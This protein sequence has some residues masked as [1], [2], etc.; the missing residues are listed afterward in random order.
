MP[1]TRVR[2]GAFAMAGVIAG[3]AGGLYVVILGGVG[4]QTFPPSDSILVFSMAV[5]G[6]LGSIS[7]ALCG[8]ALIEWLGI[9]FPQYQLVLTGFG[10]L[11]LLMFFP[12][13]L[14]GAFEWAR[15]RMLLVIARRRGLS[16]SVWGDAGFADE[17]TVRG[18]DGDGGRRRGCRATACR[19]CAAVPPIK[20]RR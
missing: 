16:T 12:S 20:R 8:V 10:M 5:I 4:Y 14:A 2:L 11:V 13:G 6:G 18:S 19:R 15:D 9:A 7:G 3:V 17:V 1:S